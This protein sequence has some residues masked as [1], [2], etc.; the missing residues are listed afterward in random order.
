[1][2]HTRFECLFHA[3]NWMQQKSILWHFRRAALGR[4]DGDRR[5]AGRKRNHKRSLTPFP[6]TANTLA[7]AHHAL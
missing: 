7:G 4:G 2:P 5:T 3:P 6:R 1:M